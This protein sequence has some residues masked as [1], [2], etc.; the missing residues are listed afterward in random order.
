M[1]TADTQQTF[2]CDYTFKIFGKHSETF[3]ERVRAI[4]G[5]TFGELADAAVSLRSSSGGRYLSITISQW[6]ESREQLEV[7][8]AALKAEPEV[9]LY[10]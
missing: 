3:V 2:P 1:S 6:V 4:V 9:L 8:Y 7:V 5:Q 10:I